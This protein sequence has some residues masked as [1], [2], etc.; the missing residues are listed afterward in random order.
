[1]LLDLIPQLPGSGVK[2]EAEF[3]LS[4]VLRLMLLVWNDILRTLQTPLSALP[5]SPKS[6]QVTQKSLKPTWD[7]KARADHHPITEQQTSRGGSTQQNTVQKAVLVVN[8][9]D[10]KQRHKDNSMEKGKPLQSLVLK[11]LDGYM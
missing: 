5:E 10:F 9:T 4:R 1:M 2:G 3:S 6:G 8:P 7:I 11:K